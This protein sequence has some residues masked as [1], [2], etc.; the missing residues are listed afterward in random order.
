MIFQK[1]GLNSG[2]S[3]NSVRFVDSQT[4][5]YIESRLYYEIIR[6]I[7]NF[8]TFDF[9][10]KIFELLPYFRFFHYLRGVFRSHLIVKNEGSYQK[11]E[12]SKYSK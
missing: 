8:E 6:I 9:F 7:A 10:L 11:I 4:V 1:K 12:K 3:L 2:F 5:H